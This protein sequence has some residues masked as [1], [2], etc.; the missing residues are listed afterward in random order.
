MIATIQYYSLPNII[1]DAFWPPLAPGTARLILWVDG[2][3]QGEY[4]PAGEGETET[5]S[6]GEG[7][8]DGECVGE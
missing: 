8:G 6:E 4:W 5:E 7:E 3:W 1:D 2:D